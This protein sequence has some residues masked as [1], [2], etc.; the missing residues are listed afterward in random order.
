MPQDPK[1]VNSQTNLH[2]MS[3]FR[4][5]KRKKKITEST[6]DIQDYITSVLTVTSGIEPSSPSCYNYANFPNHFSIN[7]VISHIHTYKTHNHIHMFCL[8]IFPHLKK[9]SYIFFTTFVGI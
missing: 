8:T 2:A 1:R 3:K 5:H 6:E 4:Q 9:K 7:A